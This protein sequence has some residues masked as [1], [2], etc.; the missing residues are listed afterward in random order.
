MKIGLSGNPP[1]GILLVDKP[2]GITSHDVVYRVR[3]QTGVRRVGHAGTLDPLATGLLIVLVGREFT[4]RQSEFLKQDKEYLCEAQLGIETDTY[5]VDGQIVKIASW[6]ELGNISQVDLEKVLGKFRGEI[7]QT[8]PAFSAVKVKGQ[9]L[10]D[11][12]RRGQ[13]DKKDLPSREVDIKELELTDFKKDEESKAIF[14]N[15]KV[16]CSSGTYIRSLAHD[17]GQELGVGATVKELRRTKI[18]EFD[19]SESNYSVEK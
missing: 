18:G 13:I 19:I 16:D 17:I 4:K 15:I 2:T 14:F 1:V 11:K 10:Y 12:A 8:V 5:D 6:E 9:K 7:A 3:K